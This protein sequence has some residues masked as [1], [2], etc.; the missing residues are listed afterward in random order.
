MSGNALCMKLP[1]SQAWDLDAG[2]TG[3]CTFMPMPR[4]RP[5]LLWIT[6]GSDA[7]G[8]LRAR[9]FPSGQ[10]HAFHAQSELT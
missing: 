6:T 9:L 7:M 4:R 2:R 8:G 5:V 3:A 10:G 1:A